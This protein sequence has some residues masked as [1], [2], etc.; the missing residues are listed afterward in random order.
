[1]KLLR[2]LQERTFERVGESRSRAVEARVIA[3]THVDLKA[4]VEARRFR[5][6]LYY[7]LRV[8]PIEIPPLRDRRED[9]EPLARTLLARVGDRHG[10]ELRFS[11][12]ALRALLDYPWPGNVRELENAVEYAST[13]A[14]G[15][16]LQPEDLPLEI[17]GRAVP[18]DTAAGAAPSPREGRAARARGAPPAREQLVAALESNRWKVAETS[19][20]LQVS[21]TTL[22]RWMREHG[23]GR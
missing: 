8:F 10:R 21:R 5:E 7:R 13:V 2:A 4:A 18:P 23:L 6:D 14:R 11:P 9:V 12:D 1:V 15:Q 19:S 20:A 16:T 3:A 17:T 22:W